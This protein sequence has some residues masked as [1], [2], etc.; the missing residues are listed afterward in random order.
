MAEVEI[1]ILPE[2]TTTLQGDLN[3]AVKGIRERRIQWIKTKKCDWGSAGDAS[4]DAH[5]TLPLF[6]TI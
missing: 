3:S 1:K 5:H 6:I 2:A 4:V